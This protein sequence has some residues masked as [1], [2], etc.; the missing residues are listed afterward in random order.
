MDDVIVLTRQLDRQVKEKIFNPLGLK[1]EQIS[2]HSHLSMKEMVPKLFQIYN[3]NEKPELYIEKYFSEYNQTL[4]EN[5]KQNVVPGV[6]ELI[7]KLSD[8]NYKLALVTS[9]TLEQAQIVCHGLKIQN[10]FNAFITAN[11]ITRSKPHPEPYQKAIEKLNTKAEECAVIED[12]PTG[13]ESAKAAGA[14]LV[15]ALTTTNS[16]ENL[17]HADII[18]DSLDEIEI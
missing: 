4:K 13:V 17:T 10:L 9:S 5:L 11:D 18:I 14:G 2:P 1:W 16:K 12:L 7:K 8:K 15:I 6:V 3:I